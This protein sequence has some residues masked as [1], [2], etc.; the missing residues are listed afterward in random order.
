[1]SNVWFV[2]SRPGCDQCRKASAADLKFGQV[3]LSKIFT[4]LCNLPFRT[5][6]LLLAG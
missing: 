2:I 3:I 1:M 6:R 4:E 5:Q